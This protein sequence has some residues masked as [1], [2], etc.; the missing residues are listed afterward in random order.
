[1][2]DVRAN[3]FVRVQH[4]LC[5]IRIQTHWICIALKQLRAVRHFSPLLVHFDIVV[6]ASTHNFCFLLLRKKMFFSL[7]CIDLFYAVSVLFVVVAVLN[8][9]DLMTKL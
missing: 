1:M 2:S 4:I 3:D 5:F 9:F 8:S 7:R 6:A